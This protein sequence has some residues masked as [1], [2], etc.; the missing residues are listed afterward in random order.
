MPRQFDLQGHRGCRGLKPESTLPAFE[1]ALDLQITTLESDM[2]L[3]RDN[4][5]VLTHDAALTA[6]I[7]RRKPGVDVPMPGRETLVSQLTLAQLRGYLADRNPSRTA[8]P[9]QNNEVTP[10]ARLFARQRNIDPYNIPTVEELF[11]FVNAY[12]GDLGRQ[13]GKSE[14]QRAKAG[15]VYFNL[16]FK[17]QANF[18]Q[19]IGDDYDGTGPGRFEREAVAVVRRANMVRRTIVQSFDHRTVRFARGIEE[20]LTAAVLV[21]GNVMANVAEV[22]RA[23]NATIYS[24]S[25]GSLDREQIQQAHRANIKVIPWTVNRVEDMRRMIDWQVDG[26]ITDFPDRLADELNRRHIEF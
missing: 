4:V 20:G 17:R 1:T 10:V 8:Y 14:A 2:H 23:A 6:A 15:R 3:T 24:P 9:N 21:S 22:A 12:A 26:I 18:P 16:E 11:A 13:A 5:P 25:F 7:Y 19:G